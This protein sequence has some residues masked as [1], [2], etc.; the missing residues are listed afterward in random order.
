MGAA[1]RLLR[2]TRTCRPPL[3]AT[4]PP[5]SAATPQPLPP[6][7][8]RQ[9]VTCPFAPTGGVSGR[10]LLQGAPSFTVNGSDPIITAGANTGADINTAGFNSSFVCN[11]TLT[12]TVS[13]AA[14]LAHRLI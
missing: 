8:P 5:A 13:G 3:I 4:C 2:G 6:L 14:A 11:C 1:M 9:V 10:R 12:V 7:P